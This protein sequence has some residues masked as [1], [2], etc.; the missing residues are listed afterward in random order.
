MT[1][2]RKNQAEKTPSRVIRERMLAKGRGSRALKMKELAKIVGHPV[3]TVS[4]AVNH[5]RFPRVR[6]KIMEALGV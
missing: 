3:T 1:T 4:Q 5:E 2:T 6:A